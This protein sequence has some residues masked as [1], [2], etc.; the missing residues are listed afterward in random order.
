MNEILARAPTRVDLAGGTLDLWPISLLEEGARTVNAAI[1]LE[2]SARLVP[3]RDSAI[4]L[5]SLDQAIAETYP[6]VTA[7][8][9]DGR[10]GF[11]ARLVREIPPGGGID[12]ITDCAAP[13]GS[14]LGGSS[15]LG[16]AAGAALAR[17]RGE[18]ISAGALLDLVQGVET[19][20]LRVPTG[21]QDYHPALRGGALAIHYGV[22]GTRVEEIPVDI[23]WLGERMVLCFSGVARSSGVSN[24][25]MLKRYLDGERAAVE[26]IRRVAG[27]TRRMEKAL[28]AAD[29]EEAA[30]A[31]AEEWESRKTLSEKVS[32]REI[33]SQ[34]AAAK[35]AGAL[36]GK[37]CGAGGGGCIVFL[38]HPE[39][40]RRVE[41]ALE[42]QGA[43]V[44][45]ARPRR[46]GLRI[47][48]IPI[49]H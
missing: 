26:G 37:V 2:A 22:R 9:L 18:E 23:D 47:E 6:S 3:R 10:L 29:L 28:A 48:V 20:V 11:M 44:L 27:A 21:V 36:S 31:L 35:R 49:P 15:A 46:E 7:M 14:G 24:W 5:Q 4:H 45:A 43:R 8:R 12:L 17:F 25:D 39:N 13:A 33:E 38:A 40:R 16:I 41:Q 19:Q 30:A 42:E 34:M 32:N 1:D